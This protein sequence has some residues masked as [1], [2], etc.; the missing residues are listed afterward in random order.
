MGKWRLGTSTSTA[1]RKPDGGFEISKVTEKPG[2]REKGNT[3]HKFINPICYQ[4]YKRSNI[5]AWK[6][7]HT[8]RRSFLKNVF[9]RGKTLPTCENSSIA[10][11]ISICMDKSA[12]NGSQQRGVDEIVDVHYQLKIHKAQREK[13]NWRRLCIAL[14]LAITTVV[15]VSMI[16]V[17]KNCDKCF[18]EI[19]LTRDNIFLARI[20]N[21]RE[22]YLTQNISDVKQ[23]SN[24]LRDRYVNINSTDFDNEY[25]MCPI[26][27]LYFLIG[28]AI[29]FAFIWWDIISDMFFKP[30][31]AF[32]YLFH[33]LMCEFILCSI[34]LVRVI[35]KGF[36]HQ[37]NVCNLQNDKKILFQDKIDI[38]AMIGKRN[39][40][41]E[42][43]NGI[44]DRITEI[45]DDMANF[46]I[47]FFDNSFKEI[48]VK[49]AY[50][51]TSV[52]IIG[53]LNA[54][55][56]DKKISGKKKNIT[57]DLQNI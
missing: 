44:K 52:T 7:I 35:W 20:N 46:K 18:F 39:Y 38:K 11:V 57:K 5:M 51:F 41:I 15:T 42:V 32:K 22:R 53:I 3:V 9:Q 23:N 56:E 47:Y 19:E 8:F 27:I 34:F 10:N 30:R 1:R 31:R 29:L 33:L 55:C 50:I 6:F 43:L 24:K 37:Q 21:A 40:D 54:Y 16:C 36:M 2:E 45:I 4:S 12:L 14:L 49:Y 28:S 26:D 17:E 48:F 13:K 25:L